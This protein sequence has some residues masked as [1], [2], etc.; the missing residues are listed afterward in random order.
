MILINIVILVI[1]LTEKIVI[2]V[3]FILTVEFLYILLLTLTSLAVM[4]MGLFCFLL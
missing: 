1:I 2:D 4:L 3:L